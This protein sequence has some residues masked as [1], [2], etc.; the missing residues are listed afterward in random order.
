MTWFLVK[1]RGSELAPFHVRSNALLADACLPED[2]LDTL[3]GRVLDTTA[4]DDGRVDLT[5][6]ITLPP[7]R[8]W[9]CDSPTHAV[10]PM[11]QRA[12]VIHDY[13]YGKHLVLVGGGGLQALHFRMRSEAS[14]CFAMCCTANA[15][16]ALLCAIQVW[17]S[18]A[19][20]VDGQP[21]G[22]RV[23]RLG[24]LKAALAAHLMHLDQS[25]RDRAL[26]RIVAKLE[27][28]WGMT[29]EAVV[30]EHAQQAAVGGSA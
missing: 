7:H 13:T 20:L 3:V 19:R 30:S 16:H 15:E 28:A 22:G 12:P 26:A 29:L 5:E 6:V 23:T 24:K 1:S 27:A 9:P 10:Q 21:A 14:W 2:V 17:R 4:G 18:F 25:D 11:T 8:R